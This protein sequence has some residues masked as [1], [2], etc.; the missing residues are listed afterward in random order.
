LVEVA[1]ELS[2]GGG[3]V[4]APQPRLGE[5]P[6]DVGQRF[7]TIWVEAGADQP[8]CCIEPDTLQMP[9]Q[10]VHGRCPRAGVADHDLSTAVHGCSA[11]TGQLDLV[12]RFG[13]AC[14]LAFGERSRA[15]DY[16]VS[17]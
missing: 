9:Q 15:S 7:A 11:S 5:L 6:V 13:H 1:E 2:D 12:V 4:E 3:A 8:R 10:R 14:I 16:R 17:P